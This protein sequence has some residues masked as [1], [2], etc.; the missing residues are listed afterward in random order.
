MSSSG[1]ET[2]R[3]KDLEEGPGKGHPERDET[4]GLIGQNE[5]TW[6]SREGKQLVVATRP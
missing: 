2:W 5:D 1:G 6:K 3:G 4:F